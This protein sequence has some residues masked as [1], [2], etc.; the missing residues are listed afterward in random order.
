MFCVPKHDISNIYLAEDRV[1]F[2]ANEMCRKSCP[3]LQISYMYEIQIFIQCEPTCIPPPRE[4]TVQIVQCHVY[5]ILDL[6]ITCYT[7]VTTDWQW[8]YRIAGNIEIWRFGGRG[9]DR[10]I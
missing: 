4:A 9:S 2:Y 1:E 10:Q 3:I 5:N 8:I 7:S 6:Y